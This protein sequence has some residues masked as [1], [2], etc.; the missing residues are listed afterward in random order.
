MP[1]ILQ[2]FPL[3]RLHGVL[4]EPY[5]GGASHRHNPLRLT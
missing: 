3:Q 5:S 2:H 1:D 4:Y